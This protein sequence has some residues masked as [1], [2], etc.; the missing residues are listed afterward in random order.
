MLRQEP[1]IGRA[2]TQAACRAR[3][4]RLG[5]VVL[6]A[7]LGASLFGAAPGAGFTMTTITIDGSFDDWIGVRADTDNVVR[8]TQIPD[9]PDYPGQPDRDVYI[10][11]TTYDSEYLYFSWRRTAGG[12]KALTF[13]AYL[14]YEGDGLLQDTDK[15]V[16]WTVSTGNPYASF[17]NGNASILHY[18]QAR[19]GD[20]SFYHSEGDPMRDVHRT[21]VPTGDG[22]TPDGWAT[23]QDGYDVP[24]KTMDGY[25]SPAGDGI[26]C[27]GRVAWSDLGVEPGH[28]FAIHFAAGNGEAWG[29]R[30][31][32]SVTYKVIG[33]RLVEEDRG[34]VEDNIEPIMYLLH[35]GVTVAPDNAGG[36]AEGTSVTYTHTVTNDGNTSETFDLS[37]LSSQGWS[38]SITDTGGNP[39][40]SVT[41]DADASQDVRVTVSIPAG[42][43][44]GTQDTTT[45]TATSQSDSGVSDSATD[46]TRVGLVTVTPNQSGTMAPGQTI[47][48]VYTVQNNTAGSGI[49]DLTTASSLGWTTAITDAIGNP[50]TSVALGAGGS[51]QVTVHLSVPASATVGT[52]DVTRLTAT[53]QGSPAVRSTATGT[54]TVQDGLAITPDYPGYSGSGT[55]AQYA[56]TVT[57]S[58]PSTRTISLSAVSSEGW[59]VSFF[60]TDGVTEIT[61]VTVGP[62]GASE[63]VIVRI[64]V[65]RDAETGAVD[66]TVVTAATGAYSDTA[67]DTTTVRQLTTY[68]DGGYVNQ[69]DTFSLGDTVFGRATG[70]RPGDSVY[71]VWKDANGTTVQTSSNRKVDTQGMAF[72]EYVSTDSQPTG[73][74]VV[75]LYTSGGTPLERSPFTMTFDAQITALSASDAPGVGQ[76]IAV[77]S[78]AV[79]NNTSQISN[80]TMTYVIWWDGNGDGVF[81]DGDTYIDGSGAPVVWDGMSVV[82]PTH[83]TSGI[84]VAGG[85]TWSES[86]PWI[87]NNELFPNQGTYRVTATW[88]T[89][90]GTPIDTKTTEF[91]SIPTLG[92]PLFALLIVGAGYALWRRRQPGLAASGGDRR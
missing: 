74:W 46:T 26:E 48:Y 62:N 18:N 73:D 88:T 37:A 14:D 86:S 31:K 49:F 56:H 12:T 82:D 76:D 90:G 55:Y 20:G 71:F 66:T 16:V 8:D 69:T 42:A 43:A 30:N 10:V 11:G 83:V 38:V 58:W 67:T 7:A 36:G 32:P 63:Q 41:L 91:Y 77:T 23:W 57:N 87:V 34:Q 3:R 27:E 44:S 29:V 70:L 25:L 17:D 53:L 50:I 39:I 40:T 15:V 80:S 78:S 22:E 84:T 72:D 33:G 75:E 92:W 60:D 28:P 47:E 45:V 51:T 2:G 19:N 35:R 13:G 68:A 65:P 4:T 21:G 54:T 89:G 1:R 5:A 61:E 64:A 79:N 24:A 81:G 85:A 59:P 9:D 6:L 52:Q